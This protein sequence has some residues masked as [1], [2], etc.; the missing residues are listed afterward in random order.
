MSWNVGLRCVYFGVLGAMV[1]VSCWATAQRGIGEAFRDLSSDRWFWATMFDAYF[2]F[3]TVGLWM[4]YRERSLGGRLF[5]W[6]MF[7][8]LG[9]IGIAIYFLRLLFRLPPQATMSDLLLRESS[10]SK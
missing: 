2:G 4:T 5:W 1:G 6:P 10:L 8:L 3:I 7:L 9:N